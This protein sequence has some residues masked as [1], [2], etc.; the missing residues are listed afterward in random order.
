MAGA[1]MNFKEMIESRTNH[2]ILSVCQR[3]EN[4]SGFDINALK[5]ERD[6]VRR[7]IPTYQR[8]F[9]IGPYYIEQAIRVLIITNL[10]AFE[11]LMI[12]TYCMKIKHVGGF[13]SKEAWRVFVTS[14]DLQIDRDEFV[15]LLG[16]ALRYKRQHRDECSKTL[17]DLIV[18]G[19]KM[20]HL[21]G[22]EKGRSLIHNCEGISE[23]RRFELGDIFSSVL[24]SIYN[25][26]YTWTTAAAK[27]N[28][29]FG[30]QIDESIFRSF[31]RPLLPKII[32]QRWSVVYFRKL[33]TFNDILGNV[34]NFGAKFLSHLERHPGVSADRLIKE[35]LELDINPDILRPA[36][37]DVLYLLTGQKSR[38]SALL[39]PCEERDIMYEEESRDERR[40]LKLYPH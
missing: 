3:L 24:P 16:H 31:V 4:S 34:L 27:F 39:G 36:L 38:I 19:D 21:M 1:T 28:Q 13:S 18:T 33:A 17:Y 8:E 9:K 14:S 5:Y 37:W 10:N 2:D 25:A 29:D 7:F 30:C 12:F 32:L 11:Q 22:E 23:T 15:E 20:G 35:W 40:R 6:A 26:R